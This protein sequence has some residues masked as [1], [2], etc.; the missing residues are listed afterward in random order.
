MIQ[1]W[2]QWL[3]LAIVQGLTEFLPV[4][5][6]A[7]LILTS[8]LLG[9]KDQGLVMDI[10]AH[11]GS[12]LAVMWYFRKDIGRML[13][14]RDWTLFL[15]LAVASIPIALTGLLAAGWIETQLR[16]AVVIALASIVFGILLW[17]SQKA[18]VKNQH[19][20]WRLA[21]VMGFAQIFALIPGASR[22]GVTLTAGMAAGLNKTAAARFSFLLAIPAILMTSVYG[23]YQLYEDPQTANWQAVGLITLFSFIA[24]FVSIHLFLKL[25][26]KINFSIFMWYRVILGLLILWVI[27]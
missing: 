7:H 15:Q 24:A 3:V 13:S 2:F 12:L 27:Q 25:I 21:I 9:W 4:S 1:D 22:S 6:S 23:F 18:P 20:S 26:E 14:G 11:F 5:S 16:S 10:A 19:I 8:Q 17:L